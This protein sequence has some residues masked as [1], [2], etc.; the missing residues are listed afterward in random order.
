[1]AGTSGPADPGLLPA[2]EQA[3]LPEPPPF[4]PGNLFRVIGPGAI[5]LVA[6]MGGGEW[7]VGPAI[8]V[9]YGMGLFYSEY[10]A[11]RFS[12]HRDGYG[13]VTPDRPVPGVDGDV[14]I[15]PPQTANAMHHDRV[16]VPGA[17]GA[18]LHPAGRS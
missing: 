18:E 1:M 12:L 10:I 11:G 15:P 5:M 4:S 9:Q 3:D 7:L 8:G 2:W 17:F 14:F 16:V 13:F 6:S